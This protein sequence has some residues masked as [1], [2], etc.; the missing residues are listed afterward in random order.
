MN[1][2]AIIDKK[3]ELTLASHDRSGRYVRRTLLS[4]YSDLFTHPDQLN[5]RS[6]VSEVDGRYLDAQR[7]KLYFDCSLISFSNDEFDGA[8]KTE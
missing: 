6:T 1:Q 4:V 5:L 7:L 8:E 3:S 2:T